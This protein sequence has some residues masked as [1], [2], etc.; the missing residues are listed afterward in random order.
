MTH[1][2]NNRNRIDLKV[3][4]KCSWYLMMKN[5]CVCRQNATM[6]V[7]IVQLL[8]IWNVL[9]LQLKKL[10]L[11]F[12]K[13][14]DWVFLFQGHRNLSLVLLS[15]QHFLIIWNIFYM[16]H[17]KCS[18]QPTWPIIDPLWDIPTITFAFLPSIHSHRNSFNDWQ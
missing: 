7:I 3:Q 2:I 1:I 6:K 16:S 10:I 13:I 11:K 18:T 12:I 5:S 9:Y 14:K 8:R 4:K 17:V 15:C